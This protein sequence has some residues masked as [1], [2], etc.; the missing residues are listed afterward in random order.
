MKT[1]FTPKIEIETQYLSKVLCSK[2][3]YALRLGP[4]NYQVCIDH[5]YLATISW[6]STQ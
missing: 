6:Y 2:P 3:K 5:G 4:A 1:K